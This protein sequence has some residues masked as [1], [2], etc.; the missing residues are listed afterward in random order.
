MKSKEI[1]KTG[2]IISSILFIIGLFML[3]PNAESLEYNTIFGGDKLA[4]TSRNLTILGIRTPSAGFD[5]MRREGNIAAVGVVL[6][7]LA[8]IL[9]I[10]AY[11]LS[12]NRKMVENSNAQIALLS[13]MKDKEST[14]KNNDDASLQKIRKLAQLKDEG[15]LTEEEFS[16]KKKEL[17]DKI[18]DV[19]SEPIEKSGSFDDLPDL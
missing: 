14:D 18:G 2:A 12:H 8:A 17:L 15:I 19:N 7:V 11:I 4:E 13:N 5:I 9:M 16:F 3:I 1:L 10:V 6:M